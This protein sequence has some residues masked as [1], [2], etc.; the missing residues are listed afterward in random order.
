M[1]TFIYRTSVITSIKASA[2]VKLYGTID[3]IISSIQSDIRG[4]NAVSAM[5]GQGSIDST[6]YRWTSRLQK[7]SPPRPRFSAEDGKWL[8]QPIK[9]YLWSVSLTVLSENVEKEFTFKEVSWKK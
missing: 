8:T 5:S 7:Q 6:D 4:G 3:L 9:Y 1:V 2:N